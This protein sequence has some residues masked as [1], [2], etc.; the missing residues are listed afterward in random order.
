MTH[1]IVENSLHPSLRRQAVETFDAVFLG[2]SIVSV[3]GA[4]AWIIVAQLAT[5]G[6][7]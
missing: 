5:L 4:V 7:T 3:W 2:G 1:T 6:H